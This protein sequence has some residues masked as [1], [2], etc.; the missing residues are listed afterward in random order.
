MGKLNMKIL[1]TGAKGFLGKNLVMKLRSNNYNEILEYNS[2]SDISLL[3]QDTRDC[4]FVYH[5]AGVNRPKD[6]MDFMKV[7]YGLTDTLLHLLRKNKNPSPIM[8]ASSIQAEQNN[9]YGLSKKEAEGLLLQHALETGTT[10]F[11]YRFPNVFG[12]GCRPNYNSVI[13]TFCYNIARNL[14]I[15][16]QDP[17]KELKLVHIDD[18]SVELLNALMGKENRMDGCLCK[19]PAEYPIKLGEIAGLLYLFKEAGKP[20]SV[21]GISD[22]FI[23]KLYNTYMSYLP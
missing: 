17:E 18:V 12:K 21:P 23:R 9:P 6:Q 11:I 19:V 14:P 1:V 10:I 8:I 15:T 5:L 2:D 20:I 3:D 22:D 13:A 4:E 16:V 7:N